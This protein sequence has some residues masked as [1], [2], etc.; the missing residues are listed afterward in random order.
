M[1]LKKLI[2]AMLVGT[3]VLSLTAC[4]GDK[5]ADSTATESKATTTKRTSK[6]TKKE[7]KQGE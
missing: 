2:S 4:G 6:T 3:M 1:K 7:S 5:A